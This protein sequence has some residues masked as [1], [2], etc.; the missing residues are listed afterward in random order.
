M[1]KV[2][3]LVLA[4]CILLAAALPVLAEETL[5]VWYSGGVNGKALEYAAQLY[6]AQHPDVAINI[7]QVATSDRETR[8]TVALTSGD[9]T[10]LPDITLFQDYSAQRFLQL[11]PG[12]L[13]DLSESIDMSC[14]AQDKVGY[15]TYEGKVYALPFDSAASADFV[16]L[17]LL[18]EAGYGLDD[19]KDI[20]WDR[21]IEI[22]KD[23]QAKTGK[24]MLTETDYSNLMMVL[25]KS[26]ATWYFNEDGS[27]NIENNAGVRAALE[28]I[29]KLHDSGIV[30][31]NEDWA[32]FISSMNEG[33]IVSTVTGNWILGSIVSAEDQSG[34][35]GMT[36]IPSMSEDM[37]HYS[38]N[39][40][41]SWAVLSSSEKQELAVDF[42]KT[43]MT[44]EFNTYLIKDLATVPTYLPA[45]KLEC[46]S[47]P[48][49]FTNGQKVFADIMDYT[50]KTPVIAYGPYNADVQNTMQLAIDQVL[51]GTSVDEALKTAQQTMDFLMEE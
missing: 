51:A 9:M 22:G 30:M 46:A 25:V 3:T 41:S 28:T 10:G 15:W 38:S 6:T 5:T 32:A 42:L 44:D 8:L 33:K 4:L 26:A 7:E 29:K 49:A 14:F 19:L 21:Y 17:D 48:Y 35:W 11:F 45:Q 24:Y 31:E 47:E 37:G 39:G 27:A 40:G 43:F 1:K 34:L 23:V 12:C 36:T 16:R 2:L 18:A 50:A 13:A 20:T